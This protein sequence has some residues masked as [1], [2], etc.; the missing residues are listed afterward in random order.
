MGIEGLDPSTEEGKYVYGL[1]SE[2]FSIANRSAIPPAKVTIL[3]DIIVQAMILQRSAMTTLIELQ[4]KIPSGSS[5]SA[6]ARRSAYQLALNAFDKY[7]KIITA[8]MD[9]LGVN[10]EAMPKSDDTFEKAME[11]LQAQSRKTRLDLEN[12]ATNDLTVPQE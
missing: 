5:P 3:I 11:R 2:L 7:T 4:G 10:T 9:A 1:K 12:S 8:N 6:L